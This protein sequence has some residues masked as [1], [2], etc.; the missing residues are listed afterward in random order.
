MS[1]TQSPA[2]KEDVDLLPF[3]SYDSDLFFDYT[4][5]YVEYLRDKKW[6]SVNITEELPN[7]EKYV[8]V[9]DTFNPILTMENVISR[10]S[11]VSN[12]IIS[13][14]KKSKCS[15]VFFHTDLYWAGFHKD[16]WE[17][18][19]NVVK[20]IDLKQFYFMFDESVMNEDFKDIDLGFNVHTERNWP[21]HYTLKSDNWARAQDGYQPSLLS[22]LFYNTR[23]YY[24]Q[25]K[26]CSHNNNIKVFFSSMQPF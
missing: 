7:E 17:D 19:Y 21:G 18:F 4:R 6:D 14:L 13:D 12:K 11:T 15:I 8:I 9:Y 10:N 16:D 1:D 24:R 23:G 3:N 2:R 22:S 20:G 25:F 26:Y 5:L